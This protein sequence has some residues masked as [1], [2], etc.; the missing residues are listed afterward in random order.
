LKVRKCQRDGMA[1]APAA[2]SALVGLS[3]IED[4]TDS[5]RTSWPCNGKLRD[6]ARFAS[7]S[8]GEASARVVPAANRR[9]RCRLP[10]L[11][12]TRR[13]Q[14]TESGPGGGLCWFAGTAARGQ[15]EGISPGMATAR[16]RASGWFPAAGC[17]YGVRGRRRGYWEWV[18]WTHVRR[19]VSG[20]RQVCH[21]L[22]VALRPWWCRPCLRCQDTSIAAPLLRCAEAHTFRARAKG[23]KG[24]FCFDSG[25]SL[26]GGLSGERGG[27]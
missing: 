5:Y 23:I 20:C 21:S 26:Y 6:P 3:H 25:P 24:D 9:S 2:L 14:L 7:A 13:K 19:C 4:T 8:T 22:G 17:S 16:A 18:G 11:Q 15:K 1:W 10:A 27:P 12:R